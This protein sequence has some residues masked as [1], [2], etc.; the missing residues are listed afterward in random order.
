MLLPDST[1]T[2]LPSASAIL[3][4][5]KKM[6]FFDAIRHE[7]LSN[8]I[9]SSSHHAFIQECNKLVN[10]N[11]AI[12]GLGSASS[13]S[14]KS[15]GSAEMSQRMLWAI[16]N[17]RAFMDLK[18]EITSNHFLNA[19]DCKNKISD[20]LRQALSKLQLREP[21]AK[22]PPA[23]PTPAIKKLASATLSRLA[24]TLQAK[25]D[26]NLLLAEAIADAA[27]K[28]RAES[29]TSTESMELDSEADQLGKISYIK[30]ELALS[31]SAAPLGTTGASKNTA[32]KR[33]VRKDDRVKTTKGAKPK[34]ATTI[35][36]KK[37]MPF[38]KDQQ[39]ASNQIA[40]KPQHIPELPSKKPSTSVTTLKKGVRIKHASNQVI[41]PVEL[42]ST[43]SVANKDETRHDDDDESS[44]SE[45][46]AALPER[47]RS[48]RQLKIPKRFR[49][50]EKV[51]D[52]VPVRG[53]KRVKEVTADAKP[54]AHPYMPSAAAAMRKKAVMSKMV[55]SKGEED[56]SMS[57]S[58]GR[59]QEAT[60]NDNTNELPPPTIIVSKPIDQP[61]DH[62]AS[63]GWL[64]DSDSDLS[65]VGK[66]SD[67][68]GSDE[69]EAK[70]ESSN[71][72]GVKNVLMEL[73][74]QYRAEKSGNS[75]A[76][77]TRNSVPSGSDTANVAECSGNSG[78]DTTPVA[79][80]GVTTVASPKTLVISSPKSTPLP[81]STLRRIRQLDEFDQ[82]PMTGAKQ[83]PAQRESDS[84]IDSHQSSDLSD[85]SSEADDN[86]DDDSEST[87]TDSANLYKGRIT[88]GTALSKG[89][90]VTALPLPQIH[91][92]PG[93]EPLKK[94]L[95]AMMLA[96]Q[97]W[98]LLMKTR[99]GGNSRVEKMEVDA[100]VGD[101]RSVDMDVIM[102]DS[103]DERDHHDSS[104]LSDVDDDD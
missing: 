53:K 77:R 2:P 61:I 55:A 1:D 78:N 64:G 26:T 27:R 47:S 59:N 28:T 12:M 17:S 102:R 6:G 100:P 7:M 62:F 54:V 60:N 97:I 14:K 104:G 56:D 70:V 37:K 9:E 48:G 23:Q 10:I 24:K 88:R 68:S 69:D 43:L 83:Q 22:P 72:G 65:D 25:K 66:D 34:H 63:A 13:S 75:N 8:W 45:M 46:L 35:D 4:R 91:R 40:D 20:G 89:L 86:N 19:V 74:A 90:K 31:A 87:D 39:A 81:C 98:G 82:S 33:S 84:D 85:V 80:S 95:R 18:Y 51:E 5:A 71:H 103:D 38:D 94:P 92:R 49:E 101:P 93:S 73:L 50:N 29:V 15:V 76:G 42:P 44:S 99:I 21:E 67:S 3:S 52:N 79:P 36:L 58:A 11:S 57:E 96:A 41:L 16:E 32:L 30:Q